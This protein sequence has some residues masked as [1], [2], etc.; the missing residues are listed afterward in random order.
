[1]RTV[2]RYTKEEILALRKPSVEGPPESIAHITDIIS[3]EP[4]EPASNH[5]LDHDDI[6]RLWHAGTHIKKGPGARGQHGQQGGDEWTRG[7]KSEDAGLWDGGGNS[8]GASDFELADFAKMAEQF[9]ADT[10]DKDLGHDAKRVSD[11]DDPLERLMQED[12]G[13]VA[14]RQALEDD[15]V[16]EW[17]DEG[18][19]NNA[20]DDTFGDNAVPASGGP[21]ID[22][23]KSNNLMAAI[24][25]AKPTGPGAPGDGGG[26]M[27]MGGGNM[28][29]SALQQ[30]QQLARDH[31]KQWRHSTRRTPPR[32]M[33]T[34]STRASSST[35]TTANTPTS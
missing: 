1:M 5:P 9:R 21:G 15:S 13:A 22:Q 12:A 26:G 25:V 28:A 23:R 35:R 20:N 29:I 18:G 34:S 4:L 11:S 2:K 32:T 7:N 19:A 8:G 6:T 31:C 33:R 17:A 27:S 10:I 24:G 16:P 30:A 3:V 14:E